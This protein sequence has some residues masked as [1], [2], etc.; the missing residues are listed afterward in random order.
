MSDSKISVIVPIY[1]VEKYLR[2]C[3]ESILCQT[4]TNLEI[5]LVDDGSPDSCPQICDE[6]AKKDLRIKAIHKENGGLSSARN[7]GMEFVTGE[8]ISF[9]DSD[10]YIHPQ[11]YEKMLA[12]LEKHSADMV[13]CGM[14]YVNEDGSDFKNVVSSPIV[15]EILDKDGGFNK[16]AGQGYFYYV[17]AVNKLYKKSVFNTLR[18]PEGRIHE[19]EYLIHHIIDACNRIA[20]I[21]EELYYY[22]QRSESIMNTQYTVKRL[23]G[24]FAYY[25]RYVFMKKRGDK[26]L[27]RSAIKAAYGNIL[28]GI[29][30]L[31]ILENYTILRKAKRKI[32]FGLKGDLRAVKLQ[33]IWY[34]KVCREI[35]VRIKQKFITLPA[36]RSKFKKARGNGE[37]VAV[38]I[39]TPT[40]GN[41]GDQAI[42]YAE[43]KMLRELGYSRNNIVEIKNGVY[44][45][46]AK[47]LKKQIQPTDWVI[48]DG[49][50]NLGSL[51]PWEDDKIFQIISEYLNNKITVF[52]QT[53]YYDL[54]LDQERLMRNKM[55]YEAHKNLTIFFRDKTS[56]DFFTEKFPDTTA[57][58]S[59]D[60]VL[61]VDSLRFNEK[62]QGALLCL[63]EDKE[64]TLSEEVKQQIENFLLR[65]KMSFVYTTTVINETVTAKNRQRELIKKW[66]EFASSQ[67]VITDRLHGMIFAAITGTPCIALDNKS[68]K[69]SGVY[70]WIEQLPYIQ[71][72][73]SF[74]EVM[75]TYGKLINLPSQQYIGIESAFNRM[76]KD[77]TN[78]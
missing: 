76:K 9:I 62:R 16:L 66:K 51:W 32:L 6:Y 28:N 41:L 27:A 35:A 74:K 47:Y 45:K 2:K 60:I 55:I 59:P 52:P 22:V 50:G 24:A 3:I 75:E 37:K 43:K 20:C 15:D 54:K 56:Y 14:R 5:I 36:L 26:V 21:K 39:A 25:D 33:L 7:R 63:R 65:Q 78:G 46:N 23:D 13:I 58:Y 72:V 67:I 40:H 48:I 1:K 29:K 73:T 53:I 18:F 77:L 57:Y 44:L 68:K 61:H 30:Q 34:K 70:K 42:V 8:F 12:T 19:D 69:V 38:I 11:A 49:G 71:C 4:Y 64:K 31:N 10:D 17:T